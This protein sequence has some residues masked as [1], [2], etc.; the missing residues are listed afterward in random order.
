MFVVALLS[1]TL[2]TMQRAACDDE[3]V[4]LSCPPGTLIS[5]QI[6]QYGKVVPGSHAC[7][8]DVNQQMDDA[9]EICLWP[10][11]MQVSE[12]S[13]IVKSVISDLDS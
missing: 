6:A 2:K 5:I 3:M 13:S 11:E 1:G 12:Y 9:E 8:A 10:N 7:I 4:S